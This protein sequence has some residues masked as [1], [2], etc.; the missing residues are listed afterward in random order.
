[1]ATGGSFG[2]LV[3]NSRR[4]KVDWVKR[5]KVMTTHGQGKHMAKRIVQLRVYGGDTVEG[6]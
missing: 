6:R 1:M 5:S 2:R 4:C 3:H